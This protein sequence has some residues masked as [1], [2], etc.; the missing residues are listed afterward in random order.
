MG[1]GVYYLSCYLAFLEYNFTIGLGEGSNEFH[2]SVP[3]ELSTRGFFLVCINLYNQTRV[4]TT[5]ELLAGG[6]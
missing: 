6:L 1:C 5:Y 4:K 2:L 3:V